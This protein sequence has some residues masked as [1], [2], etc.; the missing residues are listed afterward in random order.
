MINCYIIYL[1]GVGDFSS[2]QLT[3]GEEWFL[4]RLAQQHSNCVTVRDVFPYS[5][6]NQ[7][8]NEQYFMTPVWQW[9]KQNNTDV[10][11]QIRNLWRFAIS[12]DDRYGRIY[13]QGIADTIIERMNAV[14]PLPRSQPQPLKIIL[15]GTSGGVQV[16]LGAVYYLDQWLKA[17]ITVVSLGGTFDGENGFEEVDRVYHLRGQRDWV[18]DL[19]SIVFP[20]RWPITVGSP[21]NQAHC[22][23]RY[24]ALSSGTHTHDGKEGYFGMASAPSGVPY[25]QLTLQIVNQLPIWSDI[26]P[27]SDTQN[28]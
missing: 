16:A 9:A 20:S 4:D 18:E 6:A 28:S 8:L 26:P 1:P 14:H 13:N 25:V 17:K 19:P 21:F 27:S 10:L 23:E 12:A 15:I 11:I 7:D 24:T 5:V 3:P 2:D 22:Q